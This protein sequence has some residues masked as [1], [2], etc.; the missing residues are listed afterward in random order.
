MIDDGVVLFIVYLVNNVYYDVYCK[1]RLIQKENLDYVIYGLRRTKSL[2]NRRKL[3]KNR[4]VLPF[5][6]D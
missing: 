2:I 1:Q 6:L 4:E 5:F 3:F